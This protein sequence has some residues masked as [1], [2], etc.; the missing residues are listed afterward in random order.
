VVGPAGAWA[1]RTQKRAAIVMARSSIPWA[2]PTLSSVAE[3]TTSVVGSQKSF[4]TIA[5]CTS[6]S[7]QQGIPADR[8]EACSLGVRGDNIGFAVSYW[9]VSRLCWPGGEPHETA[10]DPGQRFTEAEDLT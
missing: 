7:G 4:S 2:G 5:L 8:L 1:K 10:A 6:R 3:H 9:D